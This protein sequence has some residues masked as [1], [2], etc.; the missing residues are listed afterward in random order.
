M[1]L[2]FHDPG[3]EAVFDG[4][5]C[6]LAQMVCPVPLLGLARRKLVQLNVAEALVDLASPP[7]NR[8]EALRGDRMG[9]FSIRINARY[10]ICFRWTD[11]GPSDVEIVDYH[12]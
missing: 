10:R 8:L 3:T 11:L 6:R 7:G 1:I 12:G 5:T 4:L 2:S 9:T